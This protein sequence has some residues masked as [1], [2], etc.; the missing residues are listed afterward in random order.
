MSPV[1]FASFDEEDG[2][3]FDKP[4]RCIVACDGNGN[5]VVLWFDGVA[6]SWEIEEV[7]CVSLEDL[8]LDDAPLGVSVWNGSYDYLVG[9]DE[10][11]RLSESTFR[12]PTEEEW[13]AIR[14]GVS[15][16][17]KP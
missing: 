16:W 3:G 6:L 12:P 10:G 4:S 2:H 1:D 13:N 7:G 17:A 8:G 11:P 14:G 15:P 9:P 5:G